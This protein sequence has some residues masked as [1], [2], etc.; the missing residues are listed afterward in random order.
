MARR[1]AHGFAGVLLR[2]RQVVGAEGSQAV[3]NRFLGFWREQGAARNSGRCGGLKLQVCIHLGSS[4]GI[5]RKILLG[6]GK[7][8]RLDHYGELADLVDHEFGTAT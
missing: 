5:D 3:V 4:G 8:C 2:V 1:K 6:G 7:S